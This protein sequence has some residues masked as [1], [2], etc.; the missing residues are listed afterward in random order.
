[1]TA[2]GK[3]K[4]EAGVGW[5]QVPWLLCRWWVPVRGGRC[6]PSLFSAV[7]HI[8]FSPS[9]SSPRAPAMC[10]QP[11]MHPWGVCSTPATEQR[12]GHAVPRASPTL[13][14]GPAVEEEKE[15]GGNGMNQLRI[16][17]NTN[18]KILFHIN[19]YKR[20]WGGTS[21]GHLDSPPRENQLH[22]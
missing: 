3:A 21:N 22:L 15:G 11:R 18:S 14:W 13:C 4:Q 5:V 20:R 6:W 19:H 1:M 12:G 10:P 2:E 17:P 8:S 16:D 7:L 9:A